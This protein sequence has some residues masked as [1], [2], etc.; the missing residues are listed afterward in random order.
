MARFQEELEKFLDGNSLQDLAV[1]ADVSKAM[2]HYY[3]QGQAPSLPVLERLLKAMK[4]P[5]SKIFG[6]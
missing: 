4:V 5:S 2:I 6:E 3:R 1:K